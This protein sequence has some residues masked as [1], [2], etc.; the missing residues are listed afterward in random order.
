MH[1][2]MSFNVRMVLHGSKG[3]GGYLYV[4]KDVEGLGVTKV[5]DRKTRRDPETYEWLADSLPG[6]TF[7][8]LKALAAAMEPVTPEQVA[9][10]AA[11]YPTMRSEVVIPTDRIHNTRCR[12]CGF[13]TS[14][15]AVVEVTVATSWTGLSD[16]NHVDLC[17]E[18]SQLTERPAELV[19]ALLAEVAV[20]SA[21][22]EERRAQLLGTPPIDD[23]DF[24]F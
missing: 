23:F 19:A 4:Y 13:H 17:N 3:K 6:Q 22:T 20:R 2:P 15:T 9:A 14:V 11:K 8:T 1:I 7:P 12:L 18:H 5:I 10:E 24:P 21:R 16:W